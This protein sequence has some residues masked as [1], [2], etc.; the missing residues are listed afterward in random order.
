M[1]TKAERMQCNHVN[2]Y[3][4]VRTTL[5]CQEPI[6]AMENVATGTNFTEA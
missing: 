4:Y 1:L 3:S 5:N 2:S 6:S